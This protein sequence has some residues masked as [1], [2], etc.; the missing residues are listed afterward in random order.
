MQI[1]HVLVE[2]SGFT[3]DFMLVAENQLSAL[4]AVKKEMG[5]QQY[6]VREVVEDEEVVDG[7][8]ITRY[9]KMK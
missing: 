3:R 1:F 7:T 5:P 8:I 9:T 4:E 2:T 6:T